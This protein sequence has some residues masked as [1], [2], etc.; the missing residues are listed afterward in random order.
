[1]HYIVFNS[2]NERILVVHLY[3]IIL[4]SCYDGGHLHTIVNFFIE[5]T[6]NIV[7]LLRLIYCF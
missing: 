3:N 7:F 6:F 1:M 5:N 4:I 2:K